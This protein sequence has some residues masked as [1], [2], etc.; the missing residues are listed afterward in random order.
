M[1]FGTVESL[2]VVVVG[3]AACCDLSR[4]V[5]AAVHLHQRWCDRRPFSVNF[6]KLRMLSP[7]PPTPKMPRPSEP[8]KSSLELWE[9]SNSPVVFSPGL[10]TTDA[11]GW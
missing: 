6:L 3:N 8:S 2:L 1:D 5:Y 11:L 10:M 4:Q 9:W 7:K